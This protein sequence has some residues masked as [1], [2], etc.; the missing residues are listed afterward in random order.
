MSLNYSTYLDQ[1][2]NLMVIGST[3]AN[4]LIMK[5]GMIIYAENRIY[6]EMDPLYAQ[7]TDTTTVSSGNRDLTPPT[8]IGTFIT[9]DSVNIITP[10]TSLSSNGTRNPLIPVSPETIDAWYPSGQT[11]TDVPL[12]YA[13]RSPT[14]VILGP[15]PDAAYTAE[16][17]GLQRPAPM[18][19]T[20]S[21]TFLTQYCPDILIAASMI[22]AVGWQ[23]DFGAQADNPAAGASWENQY[24]ML[25]QS[26]TTEQDRAKWQSAGWTSQA[27]NPLAPRK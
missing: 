23:R 19:S 17:I 13:M 9:I 26:A 2:A 1:M 14:T 22:Y 12:V 7:V 25:M 27:P 4:F 16:V 8:N 10:V 15:A 24:K 11:V 18:T 6:R 20:N 21:S 3:D 5:D